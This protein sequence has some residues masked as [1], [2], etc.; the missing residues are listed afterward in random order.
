M[1]RTSRA[2]TCWL[3]PAPVTDSVFNIGTGVETS[4]NALADTL[5]SVMQ[6]P[7]RPEYGPPRKVNAVPRRLAVHRRRVERRLGFRAADF[8][9][10]RPAFSRR[11]VARSNAVGGSATAESRHSRHPVRPPGIRRCGSARR[12]G[13]AGER[14]GRA[15]ARWSPASKRHSPSAWGRRVRGRDLLVHHGAAPRAHPGGRPAWRRSDLSVLHVHRH[16]E[17]RAVRRRDAGVRRHRARTPGISIRRMRAAVCRHARKRSS[18]CIR[19][20]SP[21]ISTVWRRSR[22][23]VCS[24]V[25]DAACAL[26]STYK[27]R[28]VGS[29]GNIACFSFHPRKSISTGEGGMITTDDPEAAERARRLRSHGASVSALSRHEARGLVFEEYAELGFNY[30]L[31]DVQAAIGVA[32]L[33]KL[34]GLLARRRAIADRYDRRVPGAARAAVAFA[35]A[36][37]QPCVSVVRTRPDAGV[38]SSTGRCA[39]RPGR[40]RHLVPARYSADSSRAA[41][42]GSVRRHVAAGHRRGR[43]AFTVPSDVR[44]AD[45]SRPGPRRRRRGADFD[46]LTCRGRSSPSSSRCSTSTTT[47]G[48]FTRRSPR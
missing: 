36:S 20:A 19:S 48:R 17:C 4:L 14:V 38:P 47:S 31:S 44:V 30:R 26:G 18:P 42:Q 25:E 33:S 1:S 39:A 41:L 46:K 32:Q 27:G 34:D 29:H 10:G 22:R 35:A 24:I 16:G 12:R 11:L 40:C 23:R 15:R 45:R 3:P 8:A 37:C 28:P 6:S 43:V 5:L 7:L 2:P 9:R 13:G 21:R